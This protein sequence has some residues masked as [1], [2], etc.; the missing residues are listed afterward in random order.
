MNGGLGNQLFQYAMARRLALIN[1][2]PLKL[3]ISEFENDNLRNYALG[4]FNIVENIASPSERAKL[5]KTNNIASK[6]MLHIGKLKPYYRRSYIKER[7]FHFDPNILKV[8]HDVYLEGYWQS[9][10]YF[11]DIEDVIR[12][13]FRVK[14]DQD[15]ANK[16]MAQN[17][18]SKEAVSI[19]IRRGDYVTD[20]KTNKFHGT[21]SLGYYLNGI[22]KIADLISNPHFFI[23]SDDHQ[24]IQDNLKIEYPATFVTHNGAGKDYEDL[25]LMTLCNHHIIANSSF[26]WWGAWLCEN[27]KKMVFAPVKWFNASE[28]DTKDL[29][30]ASWQRI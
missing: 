27:E 18:M 20:P 3:D 26:S 5:L 9:E 7:F 21:C 28:F 2:V 10:K 6:I 23:F 11:K 16:A 12:Y 29:I 17:I 1:D 25:R 14:P 15:E 30:P 4:N 22:E 8:S 24:W 13:E 19:H